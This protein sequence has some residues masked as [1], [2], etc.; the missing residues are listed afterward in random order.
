MDSTLNRV[1]H[2]LTSGHKPTKRQLALESKE[3]Q[4]VPEKNQTAKTTAR[5]LFDNFIC[6]YGFPARLHSDQGH[7]F[8][9]QVIKEL[10][11]IANIEKSRTT[12]YHPLGNGMPECFNQ[13]LLNMLGTLK[14]HQKSDWKSYVPVLVYAYNW[15]RHQSTGYSPHFLMFGRHPR[16][17]VDGF[18]DIK[19]KSA[20]QDQTKYAANLRKKLDF[21]YRCATKEARRQGRRQ[22]FIYDLK[23]RKSNMM[24][25]D[26]VLIRN[27]GLKE[28]T[29]LP[30]NGRKMSIW[31]L[32]SQIN[33]FL[34]TSLNV[35]MEEAPPKCSQESLAPIYVSTFV[36]TWS[37]FHC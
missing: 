30:T 18:S 28:K 34:F 13:T 19:P 27:V 2:L 24:P 31:L 37:R 16:L 26:R 3:C 17:A 15:T 14:N 12:P 9:S 32:N 35:S 33:R 20:S 10:C 5:L 22:K 36:Q 6:H 1:I 21:A 4:K 23:V 25:G 11:S 29:S 8:E 7:N